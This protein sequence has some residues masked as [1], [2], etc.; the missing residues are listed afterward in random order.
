MLE[1]HLS[2][3]A[4]VASLENNY[5]HYGE[6]NVASLFPPS[7]GSDITTQTA[8]QYS[9]P[10]QYSFSGSSTSYGSNS[11]TGVYAPTAY[12]GSEPLSANS[13]QA[14][15]NA[16]N[17]YAYGNVSS[18]TNAGLQPAI[19]MAYTA[20]PV[21]SWRELPGHV[22]S[23]AGNMLS[24]AGPHEY[25][26][27]ASSAIALMQLGQRNGQSGDPTMQAANDMSGMSEG[28]GQQWPLMVLDGRQAGN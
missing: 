17:S 24:P 7:D 11:H 9:S 21:S 27:S 18:S 20:G 10:T 2:P 28:V 1:Q 3:Q 6:Q 16:A 15:P 26:N 12:A 23:P 22:A 4:N 13:P 14:T 5:A 25:L 8:I 19:T